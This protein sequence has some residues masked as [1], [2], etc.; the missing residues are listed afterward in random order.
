MYDL[1]VGYG[2]CPGTF[3]FSITTD[4]TQDVGVYNYDADTDQYTIEYLP[5]L[6]LGV[7]D[8]YI[9]FDNVDGVVRP[10]SAAPAVTEGEDAVELRISFTVKLI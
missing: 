8:T 2:P 3:S 1:G 6:N 4:M 10:G 9:T 7:M 5:D